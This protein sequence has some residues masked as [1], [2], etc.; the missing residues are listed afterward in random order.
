MTSITRPLTLQLRKVANFIA[1]E[2][3]NKEC[4]WY[5][6]ILTLFV[7]IGDF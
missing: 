7:L 5:A 2:G 6:L 3:E 1:L 4:Y